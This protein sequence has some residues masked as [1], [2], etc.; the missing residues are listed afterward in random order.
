MGVTW[1]FTCAGESSTTILWSN[2]YVFAPRDDVVPEVNRLEIRRFQH[3]E[4]FL[5]ALTYM[6]MKGAYLSVSSLPPVAGMDACHIPYFG[7]V[8][9]SILSPSVHYPIWSDVWI[10]SDVRIRSDPIQ[11]TK[12]FVIPFLFI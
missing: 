11:S 1:A 5:D 9:P 2:F 3:V 12:S 7:P 4:T 6:I 8:F 10:Q